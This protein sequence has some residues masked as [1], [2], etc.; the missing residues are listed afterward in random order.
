MQ[1]FEYTIKNLIGI[2]AR[3]GGELVATAKKFTS[4]TT[5]AKGEK[6]VDLTRLFAVMKLGIKQGETVTITVEGDDEATAALAL[7]EFF[8]KNL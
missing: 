8:E 5:I 3:P 6:K 1:T 4:V 2:H 7:K